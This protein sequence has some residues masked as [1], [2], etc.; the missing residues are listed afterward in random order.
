MTPV[1]RF[2]YFVV[3]ILFL[4]GAA[5]FVLTRPGVQKRLIES[6]LPEGSSL[7]AVRITTSSLELAELKLVLPDGTKVRLAMLDVDF[8][9]LAAVFDRTIR[10]GALDV[11][12]LLVELPEPLIQAQAEP[13]GTL[14]PGSGGGKASA[15]GAATSAVP[16]PALKR[17]GSPID[18]LYAVGQL[19]WLFDIDSIQLDG[20]LRDPS[21]SRYAF[22]LDAGAIRPGGETTMEA[23]LRLSSPEA[24][25]AG[26][27]YLNANGL[28]FLKQNMDGGFEQVRLES[29]ASAGDV[30]G[31][32]LLA[33][34]Q[35]IDLLIDGFAERADVHFEFAVDV[36]RPEVFTAKL[37]EIGAF[38][39]E[40]RL[41]AYA[42][43]GTF[44]LKEAHF[45]ASSEGAPVLSLE[46]KRPF[47]LGGNQDLAGQ[48]ID[49]R[50]MNLPL[51]W[52]APCLPEGL[53]VSGQDLSAQFDLA[54]RSD[55]GLE[56]RSAA[57]LQ[58]GPLSIAQDE[59]LL[60]DQITV[61]A[62]PIIE[63]SSDA[64][65]SWD[66]GDFQVLD[67]YSELAS[68][69]STG[70]FDGAAAKARFLPSG[71]VA[72]AKLDLGLGHL[73]RQPLLSAYTSIASGRALVD[74]SLDPS[75][76]YPLSAQGVLTGLSPQ[77]HPAQ[78]QDYRFALQ[79]KQPKAKVLA[80]GVNLE[81]GPSARPSSSLQFVG[82]MMPASAPKAFKVDLSAP[83][84][85]Q[86]DIDF[87]SLIFSPPGA[88]VSAGDAGRPAAATDVQASAPASA[89]QPSA[90]PPWAGFDGEVSFSIHE[91]VL[92][93]GA[94]ITDLRARARVS[95]PLLELSQMSASLNGGSLEGAA[96]V[97]YSKRA[98]IAYQI[99]TDLTFN[100]VDPSIF[101]KKSSG[102]FP[103]QGRFNGEAKC[104]GSGATLA[105]ALEDVEGELVV[106]GREGVLS[107]FE[108]DSRSQLGLLGAGIL[109][110]QLK[111]PGITALAQA[112][113]YFNDMPFSDFTLRLNRGSDKRIMIP[114]LNFT[115]DHLLIK[116]SGFI[117]A[118]SLRQAMNQPLDLT[119]ELGAKGQ[120]IQYLES[121]QLLGP[122]ISED[123]FRRWNQVIDIG[124]TLSR[125]DTSALKRMLN[126]AARRA[127]RKPAR[128]V[129]LAED[130]ESAE[131]LPENAPTQPEPK[132]PAREKSKEER[133][134]EDI[135]AGAELINALFGN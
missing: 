117:A 127:L 63:I 42:D 68:G 107:A 89:K 14:A 71:M 87:L 34:S 106:T 35:K 95:E 44:S 57:P 105:A 78:A 110:Q 114:E 111:R 116:G 24:L 43:G 76:E 56:L 81:A 61:I 46:S 58:L 108:L 103:V 25:H 55:G 131:A 60:L 26:L 128:P 123:G 79:L 37:S 52:L 133:L 40:G 23:N 112:V 16:V 75:A 49:I 132:A 32:P 96:K 109:G 102:S 72:A 41:L 118:T 69:Q 94:A 92:L 45:M 4:I 120:L 2:L 83:R 124:G 13:R 28:L 121:L 33:A 21:G 129:E 93:S 8:E 91:L 84:I 36:P 47:T 99:E 130:P 18:A 126:E 113:P 31:N 3:L 10:L 7:K 48:L 73:A 98:R 77:A 82:Q 85:A 135:Q 50:L 62:Q 125:P 64:S 65:I 115:G 6:R 101:S 119:L 29:H 54:G 122:N 80:L 86:Q 1:R 9:P 15:T 5:L 11:D 66:L 100:E 17:P 27:K 104:V 22:N 88:A 38:N 59:Y 19:D 90:P 53:R 51:A 134:L 39:L 97:S 12:G 67:S 30:L 70:R 20:E 74:V